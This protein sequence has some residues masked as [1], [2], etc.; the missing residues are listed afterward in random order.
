[1]PDD[2]LS[3]LADEET[4]ANLVGPG[5]RM[6]ADPRLEALA[7]LHRTVA[8]ARDIETI[9]STPVPSWPGGQR[10]TGAAPV[11]LTGALRS[12]L[13]QDGDD[14]RVHRARTGICWN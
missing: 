12:A 9:S 10:E 1:M 7:K 3:R 13:R 11:G 6:L 14:L 5:R 4:R 2:E 8:Q